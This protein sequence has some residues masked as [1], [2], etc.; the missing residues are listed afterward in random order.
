MVIARQYQHPAMR[1]CAC[2]IGVFQHIHGAVYAWAFA[3]PHAKHTI[4]GGGFVQI[5]LLCAPHGGGGQVF[6]QAGLKHDVVFLQMFFRL[7][8]GQIDA[9]Q[10]RAAVA[11]HIACGIEPCARIAL[12]LQ[13]G[14][15]H[16][17]L[18]AADVDAAVVLSEF[19]VERQGVVNRLSIRCGLH[20]VILLYYMWV[21][22]VVFVFMVGT[23]GMVLWR[24]RLFADLSIGL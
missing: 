9:A 13:H 14:Q 22:R 15:T 23:V 4:A 16:Q 2:C 21:T 3:V 6:I 1:R 24:P 20:G 7:P 12:L 18:D 17:C 11:R 10:R 5:S 8:Q 19:I